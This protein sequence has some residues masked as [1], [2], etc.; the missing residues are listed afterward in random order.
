MPNHIHFIVFIC[1]DIDLLHINNEKE[2]VV[3]NEDAINRRLYG[4]V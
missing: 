3:N 4:D 2:I 1:K